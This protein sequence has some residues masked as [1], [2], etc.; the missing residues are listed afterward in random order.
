MWGA[1]FNLA[2]RQ[3]IEKGLTMGAC[4][5]LVRHVDVATACYG[6][7]WDRRIAVAATAMATSNSVNNARGVSFL[8]YGE[9]ENEIRLVAIGA[10]VRQPRQRCHIFLI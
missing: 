2:G 4:E 5:P 10:A 6:R 8:C 3:A 9:S 1:E 7:D